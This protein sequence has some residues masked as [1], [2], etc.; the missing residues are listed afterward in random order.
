MNFRE[1][2]QLHELK[3][4]KPNLSTFLKG[5]TGLGKSFYVHSNGTISND[6]EPGTQGHGFEPHITVNNKNKSVIAYWM[7]PVTPVFHQ[8]INKLK[9]FYPDIENYS[10]TV[11]GSQFKSG[12]VNYKNLGPNE[13]PFLDNK[14]RTVGFWLKNKPINLNQH[15]PQYLYHGT[16]TNL[17]YDGIKQKGLLPRRLSGSGGSYGNQGD[18]LSQVD[19]IYLSAQPDIAT[20]HAAQQAAEK[21][22]GKP[23]IIR[24]KSDRLYPELFRPDED[25]RA[26]TAQQ[27][28]FNMGTMAYQGRIPPTLIEPFQIGERIADRFVYSKWKKFE[29]VPV[30]EHPL[31]N[32]LKT[33]NGF[34]SSSSSPFYWALVDAGLVKDEDYYTPTGHRN[35]RQVVD[36]NITDDQIRKL[37]KNSP[38]V[39]DADMISKDINDW[40]MKGLKSL[41]NLPTETTPELQPIIDMLVDNGFYTKEG[42]YLRKAYFINKEHIISLAKALHKKKMDYRELLNKVQEINKIGLKKLGY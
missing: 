36:Q 23:L 19:L 12:A 20:R 1:W 32:M 26:K 15:L 42:N 38:W 41:D 40:G 8:L 2:H 17:W 33:S 39:Q 22:G 31:T 13:A 34:F 3:L 7:T 21:H 18:A 25:S 9:K 28:V 35:T 16:S 29:D 10:I 37:I 14:D 24:I 5:D 27:S 4:E 11:T 30:G 6:P